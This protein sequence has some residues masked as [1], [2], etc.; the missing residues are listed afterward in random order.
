MEIQTGGGGHRPWKSRREGGSGG[1]GNPGGGGG[2]KSMPSVGG[3]WIFF[4]KNHLEEKLTS[5]K[6][7]VN[8]FHWSP[9]LTDSLVVEQG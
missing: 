9:E 3:V 4:W 6:K 7:V 1:S 2:Q 8:A 5:L